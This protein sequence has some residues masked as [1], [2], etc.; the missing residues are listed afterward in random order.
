MTNS[1]ELNKAMKKIEEELGT[2]KGALFNELIRLAVS[3]QP[4][5][6][7]FSSE[8]P[9]LD[10]KIEPD[11]VNVLLYAAESK[12]R[13][14]IFS[15]IKLIKDGKTVGSADF[16]QI[17]TVNPMPEGGVSK[18]KMDGLDLEE[19]MGNMGTHGETLRRMIKETYHCK[20]KEEEDY[21]LRRFVAS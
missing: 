19:A 4:C 6:V 14:E 2:H 17:W 20:D 16:N 10:V 12:K 18:E 1:D 7:T 3:G 15:E 5:D 21:F 13:D 9:F 8:K 11:F